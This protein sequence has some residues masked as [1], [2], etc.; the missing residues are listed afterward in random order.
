MAATA[1]TSNDPGHDVE[2]EV[3]FSIVR[4]QLE[5]LNVENMMLWCT[6]DCLWGRG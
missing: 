6:P 2:N 5:V 3:A 1:D 4:Q